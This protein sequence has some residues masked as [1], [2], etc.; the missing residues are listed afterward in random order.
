MIEP[1]TAEERHQEIIAR[2]EEIVT[3]RDGT[4]GSVD[5]W[6]KRKLAY[7]IDHKTDAWYYVLTFDCSAEALDEATRVLAITDDVMRYMAVNRVA[8]TG[9]GSGSEAAPAEASA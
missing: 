3:Q 6:G 4:W 2:V 5:P 9:T 8:Q 1:E 7:E